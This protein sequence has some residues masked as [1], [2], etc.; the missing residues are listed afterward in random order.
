MII[1][2]QPMHFLIIGAGAIGTYFGGSLLLG[3]QKVTFIE[4]GSAAL[5]IKQD[6]IILQVKDNQH[7]IY[8]VDVVTDLKNAI[9]NNVYDIAIVAMKSYDTA[10][11]VHEIINKKITL[12]PILCL[13]NGV[14]NEPEFAKIIGEKDV[15]Y[16]SVTTAIE[17]ID[18]GSV[19]LQRLRGVGLSG[20]PEL[21]QKLE[22]VFNN[23]HLKRKY[24]QMHCL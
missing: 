10:K 6:G 7:K 17:R 14:E 18:A 4:K 20:N 9:E 2:N 13:Q 3:G 1:E 19:K 23:S 8:P 12:P 24:I 5:K 15:I 11:F 22:Q 16:G 21:C